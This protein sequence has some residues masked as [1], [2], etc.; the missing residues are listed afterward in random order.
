LS[1]RDRLKT[2]LRNASLRRGRFVLASGRESSY[3]FDGKLTTLDSAGSRLA[4]SLLLERLEEYPEV[5][6]VGGLTL[7]ADP[8][9]GALLALCPEDRPL[10]G[11]LVRK[12]PKGHGTRSQ[13]EGPLEGN[14]TVAVIEDVVTTGES[15]L[16]A[17]D[18]VGSLGCRVAVI[19]ALVDRGEG[20]ADAFRERAIP[21][22]ALFSAD[23]LLAE[24]S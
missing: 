15:A 8:V 24:N 4:A 16:K 3:Y 19:L 10:K 12:E 22:E 1:E 9:V 21:F 6:A 13:V 20:G 18:A 7:G 17:A 2:I 23:E 11:F 14:E 5:R